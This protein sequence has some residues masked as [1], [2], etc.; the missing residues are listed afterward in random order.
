M[1]DGEGPSRRGDVSPGTPPEPRSGGLEPRELER[2]GPPLESGRGARLWDLGA[3][4]FLFEIM[5]PMVTP[6]LLEAL[7]KTLRRVQEEGAGLVLGTQGQHFLAGQ[8][9]RPFLALARARRF[10][11]VRS[12]LR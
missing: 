7:H 4:I 9:W 8:D 10:E 1:P 5:E 2:H 11:E 6:P 3:G 12:Y